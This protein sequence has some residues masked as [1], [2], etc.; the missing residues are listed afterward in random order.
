MAK[1]VSKFFRVFTE[2]NTTDGRVVERSWIEDMAATYD[3]AKYGARIWLEH[4]R[5][6]LPDSPFKAYGDVRAVKAQEVEDGKLA[7]FAQ[8]DPTDDL[9]AMNK[10]RQKIYTS[11]EIDP[12]FAKSGK[13]YLAGLAVTDSPA[14]LGTEMLEFSAS[15]K[16]NPLAERKQKPENLFTAAIEAELEFEDDEEQESGLFSKVSALLNKNKKQTDGN[17]GDISKAVEAIAH[18][19]T[20]LESDTQKQL[21]ETTNNYNALNEKH[22]Q[23]QEA[24]N[25]L[26]EQ[27]S[28]EESGGQQRKPA[29]GGDGQI[30]T[31]C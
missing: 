28:N 23:L 19:F 1:K 30:Q 12:D 13:C 18:S 15:A 7:L 3:Q 14:S 25:T 6:V 11:V 21:S 31:D 20:Q 2:G 16:V 9:V 26:K 29:T 22:T 4:I 10:K 27:L 5:S 24:F 17:F 8:I